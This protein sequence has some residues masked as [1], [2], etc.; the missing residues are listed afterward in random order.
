M[1]AA[2][3]RCSPSVNSAFTKAS[4]P[5]RM[6]STSVLVVSKIDLILAA[7]SARFCSSAE[8]GLLLPTVTC[9]RPVARPATIA[10]TV[11]APA[12]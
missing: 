1:N 4:S 8:L 2:F 5:L 3:A 11:C 10:A 6:A 9:C 7:T 12:P